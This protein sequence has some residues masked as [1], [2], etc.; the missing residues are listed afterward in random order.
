MRAESSPLLRALLVDDEPLSSQLMAEM[1]SHHPEVAVVA[2]AENMEDAARLG[3]I[4][5]PNVVFLD[6]QLG[7]N[8]GFMLLPEINALRSA[9][10]IVFVTAYEEYAVSAFTASALDYLLKPVH[11]GRLSATIARLCKA[12]RHDGAQADDAFNGEPNG[13]APSSSSRMGL[14]DVEIL[15]DGKAVFYLKAAQIQAVQAEGAYTRVLFANNQSCMVKRAIGY[16]ENRLPEGL[17]IKASRSLLLNPKSIAQI[18]ARNRNE[19][20]FY[21]HGRTDPLLLS[22]LESLRARR[23]V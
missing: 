14:D 11:P 18:I 3:R 5:E 7:R 23:A 16:W 10:L 1:L 9:P 12:V 20:E 22:R 19:T 4:H 13:Q 21:L 8:N 17:F 15:K 6:V 2:V